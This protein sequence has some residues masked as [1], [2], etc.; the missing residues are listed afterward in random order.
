MH[1]NKIKVLVA[2]DSQV[3]RMLLVHVLSSDP[4][5]HVVGAVSD[6]QAAVDFLSS[7]GLHPDV[8]LMDIHM[9]RLDGFEATRRIMETQP[10]P[11]VICTATSDPQELAIA[12][13]SMEAG[14]LACIQ[15]PLAIGHPDYGLSA[16]NLLQTIQL[17]SEVKVVRRWRR[18]QQVNSLTAPL[19][20]VAKSAAAGAGIMLIGIGASTGGPPV[21]QTILSGL[22]KEFPAPLL[23]VQHIARG[24]LPGMVE[25]LNQTTGLHVQIAAHDTRALPGHA[26]IAPDD[27]H[28]GAGAGG[29]LV[30]AREPPENGL[31]PSVSYLFRSLAHTCGP[32]AVGV[33]L[34]GMGTDGA[35]ELKQM[36]DCGGFTIA[37]DRDSSV[38]HGMPGEAIGLGGAAH[39]LSADKIAA[40][41]IAQV[42][43]N[44]A[45]G[46]Y[47]P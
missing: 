8:V 24:F 1:S 4:R 46:A 20:N 39:V 43:L 9:P 12:F 32:N 16:Q 5:M 29:R 11:I 18:R 2:D 30:L 19:T 36:R 14:A 28:L 34:T 17:M 31:R 26:Y 33:L 40:A 21:L 44:S 23:I 42:G 7:G 38:V 3:T 37:Q 47:E 6:G 10:L 15:K 45:V 13:R 22:P 27:F 25:W 41:L 35:P